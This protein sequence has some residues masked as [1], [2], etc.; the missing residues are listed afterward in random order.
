[1]L[2]RE[3]KMSE[4]EAGEN[5]LD[6]VIAVC[7]ALEDIG[8]KKIANALFKKRIEDK[9]ELVSTD[10]WVEHAICD[11]FPI[12]DTRQIVYCCPATKPCIFRNVVLKK[13]GMSL[14]KYIELKKQWAK[15]FYL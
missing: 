14:K 11:S 1:M 7:S 13:M 9:L 10:E 5:E 4:E 3:R 6:N 12:V 2:K 15:L 8:E